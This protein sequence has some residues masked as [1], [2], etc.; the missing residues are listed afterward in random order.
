MG[1][2]EVLSALSEHARYAVLSQETEPA[3]GWAYASFLRTLQ[4]N[5]GIDGGQLGQLIVSSYI[6]DDARITD[7]Q[8]R[9]DLYGRGGG[10]F[11]A[12]SIPSARD[13]ASQMARGVTLAALDLGQ[14]PALMDSVNQLAY[15]LQDAEQ[16]G[17]AKAR[18][19]A[20]SF[21][22]IFGSDVPASYID[23]G[24]FVQLVQQVSGGG[25][26]GACGQ[27]CAGGD[28]PHGAGRQE[29]LG[30]GRCNGHLRLFPELAVVRLARRRP[31]LV[32]GCGRALCPGLAVG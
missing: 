4:E 29:R 9:L 18:S 23:L 11:G 15:T 3:L 10:F 22:S 24:N 25:Q 19:Y 8:Q 2:L 26:I 14:V 1:H 16:R 17:V 5:P 20:Q 27:C 28:Q 6:D 31:A 30:K 7:D 32:H 21:T 12:A 13:A